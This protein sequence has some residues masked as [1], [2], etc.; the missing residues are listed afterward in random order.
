MTETD[1][2][3][4]FSIG[5]R[6]IGPGQPAYLI[7]EVA[8]AHNGSID[9][10]HEF[11]DA[12]S[13]AG[14][15]AVKFQT[16]IAAAESTLDEPFRVPL[17]GGDKTRFD[18]W[19]RMEF[20]PPDWSTLADHARQKGL[21]FLS[22]AF[23]QEAIDLLSRLEVPAWKIAS[24]ET[25][26]QVMLESMMATGKPFLIST[27]MS[28]W[29]EIDGVVATMHRY[30]AEFALLQCTSQYPTPL[31]NIG[32]E[33]IGQYKHRYNSP[34][35]LS[36]H[37]GSVYPS[38]AAVARGADIIEMHLTLSRDDPGPDT[39]SSLTVSEMRLVADARNALAVIDANPVDKDR[40]GEDLQGMRDLFTRSIAPSRPLAKGTVLEADMLGLKKPGTGIPPGELEALV[41]KTLK[42]DVSPD[43]LL[44]R[45]DI[46]GET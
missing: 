19:K 10:A 29:T 21:D 23:S 45:D 35:G 44:K 7:A 34:A 15:D 33:I 32:L 8:Q 5:S 26:N 25:G 43:R 46:D 41:G 13:E 36:D 30:G 28:P 40:L 6:L 37:S 17:E 14:A 9:K 16:H 1:V 12:A 42:G 4:H 38:L 22:S 2:K 11:I 18:Y 27:G 24:G 31:E 20:S 3:A 39:S